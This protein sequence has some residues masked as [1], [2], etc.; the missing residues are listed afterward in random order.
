MPDTLNSGQLLEQVKAGELITAEWMNDLVVTI[1]DLLTRVAKLEG[2]QGGVVITD[3][4]YT[5][6]LRLGDPLEIRGLNFG[7]SRGAQQVYFDAV[8]ITNFHTGSNDTRLIVTVPSFADFPEEGRVVTLLVA[9]GVNSAMRTLTILPADRPI[10][11]NLVDVIWET[12]T[13]NPFSA[14]NS[15]RIGY[16]LRSRIRVARTFTLTTTISRA[17]LQTGIE[18]RELQGDKEVRIANGQIELG[19]L[20]EKLFFLQ[21]P[22]IP[23]AIT[24]GTKFTITVSA[25]SGGVTGSDTREFTV[26]EKS[27]Q[28]DPAITLSYSDF[29]AVDDAGDPAPADGL[30]DSATDTIKLKAQAFGRAELLATFTQVGTYTV[31]INPSGTVDGWTRKLETGSPLVIEQNDLD[32]GKGTTSRTIDFTLQPTGTATASQVEIRIEIERNGVSMGEWLP[33]KLA[34]LT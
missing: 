1:N 24:R 28:S 14:G 13:P 30:Y 8:S 26:G 18:L 27:L 2:A 5:S 23:D 3:L 12:I 22:K 31:T 16:R 9:N 21:F 4:I 6:P 17:E 11:G 19:S 15:P 32:T 7:Y 29:N 10:S 25:V 34:R 20:Q 33:F